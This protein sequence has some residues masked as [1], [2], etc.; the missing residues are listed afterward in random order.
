MNKEK[1]LMVKINVKSKDREHIIEIR[2]EGNRTIITVDGYLFADVVR[3]FEREILNE[4]LNSLNTSFS[5]REMGRIE[6]LS[7]LAKRGYI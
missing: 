1:E 3:E 2:F 5:G 4:I 7:D 6:W